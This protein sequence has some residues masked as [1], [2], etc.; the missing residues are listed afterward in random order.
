MAILLYIIKL[1][2]I[3]NSGGGDII[4]SG[5]IISPLLR[6]YQYP[7]YLQITLK[8]PCVE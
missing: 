6:K 2:I 8:L 4:K 7:K 5:G 3:G 1:K